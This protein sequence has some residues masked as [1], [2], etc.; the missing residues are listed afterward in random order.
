MDFLSYYKLC[1]SFWAV[2]LPGITNF[3]LL[4]TMKNKEQTHNEMSETNTLQTISEN[5]AGQFTDEDLHNIHYKSPEELKAFITETCLVCL[6]F[7]EQNTEAEIKIKPGL[8]DRPSK[9]RV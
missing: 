3:Q 8:P 9:P 1:F 4:L 6:E 2:T 7:A 5:F